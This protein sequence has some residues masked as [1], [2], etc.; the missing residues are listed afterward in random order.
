MTRRATDRVTGQQYA[1]DQIIVKASREALS[2]LTIIGENSVLG[3]YQLNARLSDL[4]G[5]TYDWAERNSLR[6]A[7]IQG[8]AGVPRILRRP[9]DS[10]FNSVHARIYEG[11]PVNTRIAVIDAN[12]SR[13]NPDLGDVGVVEFLGVP[14]STDHGTHVTGI[15]TADSNEYAITGALPVSRVMLL[16]AC[17]EYGCPMS[18]V[19]AAITY[20]AYN[21][22][23]VINLSLGGFGSSEAERAA[24]QYAQSRGVIIVAAAGNDGADASNYYP[25]SYPNVVCVGAVDD[26]GA[27]ASFSN[28]GAG[29]DL[30]APGVNV[31]STGWSSEVVTMSGTSMSTPFVTAAA[32]LCYDRTGNYNDALTKLLRSYTVKG[33]LK[34]VD[35]AT[36][37][38][39]SDIPSQIILN[40]YASPA[41]IYEGE[42]AAVHIT[43]SHTPDTAWIEIPFGSVSVLRWPE[44]F[45]W[46]AVGGHGTQQLNA[47]ASYGGKEYRRPFTVDVRALA[48]PPEVPPATFH[49]IGTVNGSNVK[50]LVIANGSTMYSKTTDSGGRF[51]ITIAGSKD[52]T[53]LSVG[54]LSTGS[55]GY[56]TTFEVQ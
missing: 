7:Q 24:I 50:V 20:A 46:T 12:L 48:M 2:G 40:A 27:M 22:I 44:E 54:V 13:S 42:T 19:S 9:G 23:G 30:Y 34:V 16:E 15:I 43:Y 21:G 49:V 55:Q 38:G 10:S 3:I 6:S 26:S 41:Y 29:V 52:T 4:A 14:P 39:G 25:C 28:R 33:S 32:A 11:A 51:D 8:G 53:Q 5:R 35:F 36:I 17:D 45:G 31:V 1:E 47:V 56:T 37:D 18:S